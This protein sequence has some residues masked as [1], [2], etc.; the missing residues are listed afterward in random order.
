M[1]AVMRA[2]E[3]PLGA[4]RLRIGVVRSGKVIDERLVERRSD[5]TI[6]PSEKSTFVV[7]QSAIPRSFKL[8]EHVGRD[9]FL[10]LVEGMT[11]RVA[12]E[13][14]ICD[15]ATLRGRGKRVQ[16]GGVQASQVPLT[17]DAR[18]KIVIADTTLLFQFVAPPPVQATPQLPP[19]VKSSVDIDWTTTV[20]A[21]FSFLLHF[22]VIGAIWSDPY[23]RDLGARAL[24][25]S[26]LAKQVAAL[27]APPPAT[28]EDPDVVGSAAATVTATAEAP[29]DA[30]KRTSTQGSARTQPSGGASRALSDAQ[31]SQL[32]SQLDALNVSMQSVLNGAGESTNN[33]LDGNATLPTFE[34]ESRSNVGIGSGMLHLGGPGYRGRPGDVGGATLAQDG[35]TG[36]NDRRA[37]GGAAVATRGPRTGSASVGGPS[38]RGGTI[39]NA[40]AVVASM[41][42][43]FRACYNREL[44]SN[45]DSAGTVHV[46]ATVGPAGEVKA[47]S[48]SG[49]GN[50]SGTLVA[51]VQA[52]VLGAQFAAPDGGGATLVIP[53]GFRLQK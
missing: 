32:T 10:N 20:I 23:D 1:T 31:A 24:E 15:L 51:C 8:F 43:G 13:T 2:I 34:D 37:D 45:P 36:A 14:G 25:L 33:V 17:E 39:A 21:A 49:G 16:Q 52:R 46:T 42:A 28:K 53:V 29:K 7:P 22:G 11:G 26:E 12:L 38:V 4:K 44:A 18:G 47:A 3:R 35:D 50:L 30:A 5:V 6:G 9:C 27:P 40:G 41:A 48:A 19:S